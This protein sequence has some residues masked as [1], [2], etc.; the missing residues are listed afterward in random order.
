MF[1]YVINEQ[2]QLDFAKLSNDFN[3]I[4]VDSLY[5][6]RSMFGKQLVHGIHQVLICLE[7]LAKNINEKIFIFK[8]SAKFESPA[9]VNETICIDNINCR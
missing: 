5:A 4:H 7:D 2:R 3:P 9:G 8:I 6:W 1:K